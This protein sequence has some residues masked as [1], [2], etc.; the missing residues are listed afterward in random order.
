MSDIIEIRGLRKRFRDV[1]ALDGIDLRVTAGEVVALLG[2]NGAGKTTLL[3]ILLGL[4]RADDGVS[5]L[6]GGQ[7]RA[8][9]DAGRVGTVLQEG[10]PLQSVT[11]GELLRM[12]QAI[13]PHPMAMADVIEHAQ[14]G[15]LLDRR[16]EKLSGG[17]T[18]RLR[19]GV[20]LT[21]DPELLVL[22]EPTAAMDVGARRSFWAMI[23]KLSADGRTILFSTHYLE[24]ADS[25][26]DRI[27]LLAAGKVVA[28]GPTTEIRAMAK[29]HT[30]RFT[31]PDP[32]SEAELGLLPGVSGVE[33]NGMAITL[34]STDADA[35]VRALLAQYS[36]ARD[37]EVVA[38]PLSDVVFALTQEEV[39][40]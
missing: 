38:A 30:I 22:D 11:V 16:T 21:G 4:Q 7:A 1:V 18:Q 3:D 31:L 28:D 34:R 27:V 24:E 20:A 17:E 39:P 10:E 15:D 23:R 33:L 9:I 6:L 26:A 5:R 35:T 12:V 8:A 13:H 40:A 37:L 14:L 29:G 32:S 19:F 25:V 36:Q 2:P